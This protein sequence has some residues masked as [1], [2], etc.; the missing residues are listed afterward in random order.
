MREILNIPK[1]DQSV[2]HHRKNEFCPKNANA[3]VCARVHQ[4]RK[5]SHMFQTKSHFKYSDG[6]TQRVILEEIMCPIA[7]I[8]H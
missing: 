4:Y 2:V 3:L 8:A 1:H 7:S 6:P 5:C